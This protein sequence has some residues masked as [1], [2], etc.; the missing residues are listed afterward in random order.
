VFLLTN[1]KLEAY[2]TNLQPEDSTVT[3]QLACIVHDVGRTEADANAGAAQTGFHRDTVCSVRH[4][5]E[6]ANVPAGTRFA[7][8][9]YKSVRN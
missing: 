7:R 8:S 9:A 4:P 5:K 6:S 3:M 2:A 1:R